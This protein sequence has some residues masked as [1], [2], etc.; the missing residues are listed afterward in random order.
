MQRVE[1]HVYRRRTWGFTLK[2]TCTTRAALSAR[3]SEHTRTFIV[4]RWRDPAPRSGL[5]TVL[6]VGA[7]SFPRER[8]Q[9]NLH[10][11]PLEESVVHPTR[12]EAAADSVHA[13][14]PW[15][16]RQQGRTASAFPSKTHF[17]L[18]AFLGM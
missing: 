7:E 12:G 2:T 15:H 8:R 3:N 4:R 18:T 13:G 1:M 14:E 5:M 16:G 6:T 17:V 11:S 10:F 9:I